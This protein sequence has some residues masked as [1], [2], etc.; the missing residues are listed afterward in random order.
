MRDEFPILGPSGQSDGTKP[1]HKSQARAI[2]RLTSARHTFTKYARQVKQ[3]G[4]SY[5]KL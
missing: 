1:Q 2:Q 5:K 3:R 4:Q